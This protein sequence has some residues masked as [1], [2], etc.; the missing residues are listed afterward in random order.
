MCPRSYRTGLALL[1]GTLSFAS[2]CAAIILESPTIRSNTLSFSFV[3]A[4]SERIVVQGCPPETLDW[5][6]LAEYTG[7]G[8][9]IEHLEILAPGAR[10]YRLKVLS[11]PS[12]EIFPARLTL[13]AGHFITTN[14]TAQGLTG[15]LAWFAT[16]L[17][18]G[19]SLSPEGLLS[20]TP[21]PEA[22][23]FGETGEHTALVKIARRPL[24]A[25]DDTSILE[26]SFPVNFHVRL[27]FLQNIRATRSDGPSLL[28]N[29]S[30]CHGP[31][32]KPN[33]QGTAEDLL[34][35]LSGSGAEC[36][37]DRFYISPGDASD[38][39]IY[40]KV[41]PRVNCGERMPF[42]GPYLTDEQINRLARWIRELEPGD[43]D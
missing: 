37:A 12:P 8:A 39:L 3:S 17:P 9:A 26:Y 43:E 25:S 27:S 4:A 18:G 23:E 41:S 2:S 29:C 1:L 31:D 16:G 5:K 13:K 20:G 33:I 35:V 6:D 19:L 40:E 10:L 32:F 38:S 24:D 15:S 7:T 30:I 42:D 34:Y 22:A 36:G 14:F 11:M 21:A 28:Q